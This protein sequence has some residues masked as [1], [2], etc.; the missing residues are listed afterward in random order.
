MSNAINIV[1]ENNIIEKNKKYNE[2]YNKVDEFIID[3]QKNTIVNLVK[4]KLKII[5]LIVFLMIH[6][7]KS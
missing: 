2:N 1:K 7:T 6:L 5:Y 3:F 4:L